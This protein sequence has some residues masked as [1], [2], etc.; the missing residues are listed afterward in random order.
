[1]QE[2]MC[3]QLPF[4]RQLGKRACKNFQGWPITHLWGLSLRGQ[5]FFFILM[6]GHGWKGRGEPWVPVSEHIWSIFTMIH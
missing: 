3:T 5:F 2:Y 6:C 4:L 1:M